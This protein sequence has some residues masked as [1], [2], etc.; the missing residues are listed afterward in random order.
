M[1]SALLGKALCGRGDMCGKQRP[2]LRAGLVGRDTQG[3]GYGT[4]EVG[5]VQWIIPQ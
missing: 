4:L 1:R 2:V 3:V 5:C